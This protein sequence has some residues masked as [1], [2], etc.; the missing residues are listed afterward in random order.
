MVPL[1]D[2]AYMYKLLWGVRSPPEGVSELFHSVNLIL[3]QEKRIRKVPVVS[4][5][6]VKSPDHLT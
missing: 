5:S 6:S 1:S 4:S 2:V 3:W